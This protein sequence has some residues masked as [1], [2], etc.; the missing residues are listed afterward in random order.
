M[1]DCIADYLV[2][3]EEEMLRCHC[4]KFSLVLCKLPVRGELAANNCHLEDKNVTLV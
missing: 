3:L 1:Q 4:L 2:D